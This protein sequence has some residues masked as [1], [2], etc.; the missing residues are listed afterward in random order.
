MEK[1]EAR[2]KKLDINPRDIIH[3]WELEDLS[4][5]QQIILNEYIAVAIDGD[6]RGSCD[7]A[8]KLIMC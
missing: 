8:I 2:R 6:I 7:L 3:D 1:I 5:R 4:K